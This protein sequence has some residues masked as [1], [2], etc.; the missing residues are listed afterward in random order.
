[1]KKVDTV[2]DM[3][4]NGETFQYKFTITD[5]D[6]VLIADS[7]VTLFIELYDGTTDIEAI[8]SVLTTPSTG[9]FLIDYPTTMVG[10]LYITIKA[11]D[12]NWEV[13]YIPVGE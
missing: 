2:A 1:M 6:G 5:D 4:V 13:I 11:S 3:I 8:G 10:D 12:G 9:V 7:G